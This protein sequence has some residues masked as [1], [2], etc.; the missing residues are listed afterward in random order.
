M[1][2]K[3]TN[4]DCCLLLN[5]KCTILNETKCKGCN[6]YKSNKEFVRLNDVDN[7]IQVVIKRYN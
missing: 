5:N 6:F 7:N 1:N 2:N 4:N 3:K